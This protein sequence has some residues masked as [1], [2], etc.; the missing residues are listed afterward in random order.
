LTSL[1]LSLNQ[2][3]SLPVEIGNLSNLRSLYL[4]RNQLTNLPPEI[5]NLKTLELFYLNNNQLRILPPEI[6]KL[7]DSVSLF[8]SDNQLCDISVSTKAWIYKTQLVTPGTHPSWH[9]TQYSD[10]AH[11]ILCKVTVGLESKMFLGERRIG[12]SI[13]PNPFNQSTTIHFSSPTFSNPTLSIFNPQGHLINT[14]QSGARSA[15]NFLVT[16]DG[17]DNQGRNVASGTYLVRLKAGDKTVT[18][19]INLVR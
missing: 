16:W 14:I 10:S 3:T 2:L 18:R 1:D 15:G 17:K 12:F 4:Y 11:T 13:F 8:L 5:G 9:T 7:P 6:V 19:R